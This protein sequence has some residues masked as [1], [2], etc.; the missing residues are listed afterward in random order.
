[1]DE[2]KFLSLQRY[3]QFKAV[4][5]GSPL[6][7]RKLFRSLE[8]PTKDNTRIRRRINYTFL[9]KS[10]KDYNY[11]FFNSLR[12]ALVRDGHGHKLVLHA[13]RPFPRLNEGRLESPKILKLVKIMH[14]WSGSAA[15]GSYVY[16]ES[17]ML[18]APIKQFALEEGFLQPE[19]R[20][21]GEQVRQS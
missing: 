8:I 13:R 12:P 2:P 1:M 6:L 3:S 19:G 10:S 11:R 18:P 21:L 15:A 7:Q 20:D 5:D 4:I 14:W 16:L 17:L 9:A